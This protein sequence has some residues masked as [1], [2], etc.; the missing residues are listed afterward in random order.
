MIC[1]CG[2]IL[3][4]VRIEEP[5]DYLSKPEKL[6]YKRLCDVQCL[7]CGKIVYSQPYD[8]GMTRFNIVKKNLNE[9]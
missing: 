9:K 1:E 2:G 5:P 6:V 4:V 8:E 3:E 7:Q